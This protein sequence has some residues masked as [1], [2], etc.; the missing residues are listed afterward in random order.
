MKTLTALTLRRRFGG[1]IDEV[2]RGKEPVV[3]TRANKPL[4]VILSYEEY[5]ELAKKSGEAGQKLR[6]TL[7]EI[8][9]WAN[10]YED[11]LKGLNAVSMIRET[12]Q[13]R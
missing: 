11:E 8:K 9:A 1:I 3:I 2:C 4:V 5:K 10:E 13:V 6:R 7:Q 12:R